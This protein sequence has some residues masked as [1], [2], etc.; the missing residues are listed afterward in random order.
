MDDKESGGKTPRRP[1]IKPVSRITSSTF[2]RLKA[3]KCFNE[4]DR[5]IR[6]GW[7]SP[8]LAEA[9]Q[10][11]FHELQDVSLRYLKKVLDRYRTSIPPSELS[12]VSPSSLMGKRITQKMDKG[13]NE[14]E[15]IELLYDMQMKRIAI[16]VGNEEKINKLLPTTGNEIYVAMKLLKQS[17]DLKMDL[18]LLKRQLGTLEMTGQL[19]AEATERYGKDSVGKV[20]ADPESRRKVLGL[21]E[22]LI[23][24]G[25]KASIDSIFDPET[26]KTVYIDATAT[27]V[28][29]DPVETEVNDGDQGK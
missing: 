1:Q 2:S 16:D 22:K 11:E 6:L 13:L 19:A 18:G 24:M 28:K 26:D 15:Q 14:L 3:A 9:I 4:I 5:R 20:L 12:M 8:D 10:Q 27:E 23:A 17:T 7:S 21:A 25:A 29:P